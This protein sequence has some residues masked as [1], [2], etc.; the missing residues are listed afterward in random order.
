MAS[1]LYHTG[2]LSSTPSSTKDREARLG[3]L[4]I[5]DARKRKLYSTTMSTTIIYAVIYKSVSTPK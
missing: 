3:F 5:K 1:S 2:V 4:D